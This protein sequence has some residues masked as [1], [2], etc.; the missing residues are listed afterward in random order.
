MNKY[1][2]VVKPIR[3]ATEGI[4]NN[5]P[6]REI[7]VRNIKRKF[8]K[9]DSDMRKNDWSVYLRILLNMSLAFSESIT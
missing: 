2:K 1:V 9:V 8:M 7:V 4:A 3:A 6:V 5:S